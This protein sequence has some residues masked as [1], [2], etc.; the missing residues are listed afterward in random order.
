[1][2]PRPPD[3]SDRR[4]GAAGIAGPVRLSPAE[5]SQ[6]V[7]RDRSGPGAHGGDGGRARPPDA[8]VAQAGPA[9]GNESDDH[10]DR[11]GDP[12]VCRHA[13]DASVED[14]GRRPHCRVDGSARDVPGPRRRGLP[15]RRGRRR[16]HHA[17]PQL[18]DGGRRG[19]HLA[20]RVP[21]GRAGEPR[22]RAG[23]LPPG[24]AARPRRNGRGLPRH[25]PHAGSPGRDQADPPRGAGD[26]RRGNGPHGGGPFPPGSRGRGQPA[27][28]AHGG[29]LR[30]RRDR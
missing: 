3:R 20:R 5:P 22:A 10:L 7:V 2:E 11:A 30:L 9:D 16:V 6:P 15:F 12:D 23:Q 25:A 24:R 4:R 27:L 26:G 18:P 13:A 8:L 14:A 28:T 17:L 1:M 29:A 19:R 21:P